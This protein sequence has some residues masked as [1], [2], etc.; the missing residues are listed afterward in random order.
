MIVIEDKAQS[1]LSFNFPFGSGLGQH[2]IRAIAWAQYQR[3]MPFLA[4]ASVMFCCLGVALLNDDIYSDEL[5]NVVAAMVVAYCV[6]HIFLVRAN[7]VIRRTST[8]TIR[9]A[10][11]LAWV[12]L[13]GIYAA[14]GMCNLAFLRH[15][16]DASG[17]I[18]QARSLL[19][20]APLLFFL[21]AL[22]PLVNYA[23]VSAGIGV[24]RS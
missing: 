3:R 11:F 24:R 23:A 4:C 5:F 18:L 6:L 10:P 1:G 8:T 15:S 22:F 7:I 21:L 16:S 17:S 13:G 9:R 19:E 12:D 20:Y 2:Y 14:I